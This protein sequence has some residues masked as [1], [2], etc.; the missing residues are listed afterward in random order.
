MKNQNLQN[1]PPTISQEKD[2]HHCINCKKRFLTETNLQNHKCSYCDLCS[3]TLSSYQKYI[4]HYTKFHLETKPESEPEPI[5]QRY[6]SIEEK[7]P[8]NQEFKNK[9]KQCK[10]CKKIFTTVTTLQCHK[11]PY[12]VVCLKVFS[13][14][15]KYENHQNK[16]H[17]QNR[18]KCEIDNTTKKWREKK[19]YRD[20]KKT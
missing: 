6:Q 8:K 7:Y 3:I 15:Q 17:L 2:L 20:N 11:C 4:N 5:G 13:S 12:C 19:E 9:E 10:S 18:P 16:F 1:F 14:Y